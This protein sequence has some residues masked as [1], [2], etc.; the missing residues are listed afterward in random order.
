MGYARH[1]GRVGALA[2]TLG[3]GIA[4]GSSPGVAYAEPSNARANQRFSSSESASSSVDD[5][6]SRKKGSK[7]GAD[8]AMSSR[9]MTPPRTTSPLTAK[10]P[11][12]PHLERGT[13][14]GE[15][16]IRPRGRYAAG[17]LEP[18]RDPVGDRV[19]DPHTPRR[20]RRKSSPLPTAD[21]TSSR[22]R[23]LRASRNR[24]KAPKKSP[25]WS[26]VGHDVCVLAAASG[27]APA[28]EVDRLPEAPVMVA[29][30]AAV[31]DERERNTL[32]RNA[33][34]AVPQAVTALA[35]DSAERTADRCGRDEP[36]QDPR[37]YRQLELLRASC[38]PV[39]RRRRAS[40]ATPPSP[41][42]RGPRS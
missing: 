17:R 35:D 13:N 12:T 39:P 27:A 2:I 18:T 30:L 6:A 33:T 26:V 41:T 11:T 42:P 24:R 32:R 3:V 14:P 4:L 31:R 37:Q 25:T 21:A 8:G 36:Q 29:A 19:P 20:H 16:T 15:T 10:I 40:S 23:R 22:R 7:G 5:T 1:V 9:P 28:P 34:A 38:R